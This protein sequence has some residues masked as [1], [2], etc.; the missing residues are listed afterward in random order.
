LAT[1][2]L[3]LLSTTLQPGLGKVAH[4]LSYTEVSEDVL[5]SAKDGVE[6]VRPVEHFDVLA[7]AGLRQTATAP[8]LDGVVGNVLGGARTAELEQANR[9]SQV[10]GLLLVGHVTHLIGDG[11]EPRLVGLDECEH[12]GEFLADDGLV[13]ETLA[14]DKT[15]VCPLEA[16][17]DN[18]AVDTGSAASHGP[19]LVVEVAENDLNAVVLLAEEVS[20]GDLDV[21]KGNVGGS[22]GGG[23]GGLDG[24][25]LNALA[26]GD[27]QD[28]QG[29]ACADAGDKVVGEAAVGDPLLGAVD[30]LRAVSML[31]KLKD[32]REFLT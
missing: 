7:H 4:G 24:L 14:K 29:L 22:G 1:A 21:V 8:D 27:E 28:T 3:L 31:R 25:C 20:N 32:G 5:S 18:G 2:L 11:L 9:A 17:F 13:H 23:V 16:L 12:L 19:P 15:L 30:N 6:A 10:L 26:A